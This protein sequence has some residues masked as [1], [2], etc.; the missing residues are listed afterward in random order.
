MLTVACVYN[1]GRY[2][3]EWVEKLKRGVERNLAV[4]HRFVCLSNEDVSCCDT[5]PLLHD[6][7][8]F[9]SKIELFR[10]FVGETLYL[11]L[12]V[13]VT[14]DITPL[15]ITNIITHELVM[16]REEPRGLANSSVMYWRKPKTTIYQKFAAEP[17]R[18]MQQYGGDQHPH[19]K[20]YGDQAFIADRC[21]SL[22]YWNKLFPR[23]WFHAFSFDGK[24]TSDIPGP[25][26]R[27]SVCLGEPKFDNHL[28]NDIVKAHWR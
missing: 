12:D 2:S 28:N 26:V 13:L 21:G 14:G 10:A 9:W 20:Q 11:D 25:D 1:G 16:L 18:Y 23:E 27:L 19:Y 8:G 22:R 6:W 15:V 4:Q 5:L 3:Q 24:A 7:P 17:D